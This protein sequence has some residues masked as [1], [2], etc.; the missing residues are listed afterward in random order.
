MKLDIR[1]PIGLLFLCIGALLSLF[2][3]FSARG[4]GPD[5]RIDLWWGLLMLAFGAVMAGF[6]RRRA[7]RTGR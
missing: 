1:M 3:L 7:L 5:P 4:A 2:G 6:A